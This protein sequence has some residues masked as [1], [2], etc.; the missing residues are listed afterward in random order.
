MHAVGKKFQ[1]LKTNASVKQVTSA[2]T[3]GAAKKT[4]MI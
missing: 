1:F 2:F 4:V 3:D